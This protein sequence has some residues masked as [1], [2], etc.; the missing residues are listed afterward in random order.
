MLVLI[1]VPIVV[2]GFA[3]RLNALLVVTAAGIA[4]GLAG[5]LHTVEIVSAFGKAF[6]DNRYMGLVWLTLPVIALLERNGL[7]E[8]ARQLISRVQAATTGRVLMLYFVV[9]QFT[10]ALG[11]TSLGGHAQ[12]VRPLIAPMAEAAATKRYGEVPDAVRQQIRANASAVDNIAVFF[13]EDIFIAIQSI[14]LIKGFLEQNGIIV[15][16]LQVSVWAI[17][18]A[19]AALIIHCVRLKLLDHNLSRRL[20][21]AGATS[22]SAAASRQGAAS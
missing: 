1:G 17:P 7:R 19:F 12:M 18:T 9:R 13:G 11:L 6:A 8:Q 3:L 14:L 21:V 20:K 10:A 22:T 5:G 4:T 2:I 16:P 15:Q